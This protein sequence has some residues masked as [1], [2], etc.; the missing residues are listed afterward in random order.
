MMLLVPSIESNA[1]VKPRKLLMLSDLNFKNNSLER[2]MIGL[3]LSLRPHNSLVYSTESGGRSHDLEH[4]E[5]V[6]LSCIVVDI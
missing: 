5:H 2:V 4:V 3:V 6:D 1:I